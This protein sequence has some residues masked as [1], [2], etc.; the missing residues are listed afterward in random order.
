M[1]FSDI[2]SIDPDTLEEYGALDV[3]L[4]N[5][6]P[7]FVDPFLL[8]NSEKSKY[9]ILHKEIIDYLLFLRDMSQKGSISEGLIKHWFHFNEVKQNWLGFSLVGNGGRGLGDDFAHSLYGNLNRVLSNFGDEEITESSH[10]EKLCLIK[11]GVGKDSI[12]DFT[13]NL[14]KRY[15]LEYSQ[16]FGQQYLKSRQVKRVTVPRAYFNYGTRTWVSD[17][18]ALPFFQGDYVL[19]TP[20]DILARE[21]PWINNADLINKFGSIVQTVSNQELRGQLNQYFGSQLPRERKK[22]GG[23]KKPSKSAVTQAVRATINQYPQILDYYIAYKEARG[24]EA[25]S[26]S[27]AEVQIT[28]QFFIHSARQLVK[29]LY[30]NTA[31][32]KT[33]IN[34]R[35]AARQRILYLKDQIENKGAHRIFYH[36][37]IPTQRESDL[38]ILFRLTW[39]ATPHN[40]SREVNDGRG[41]VDYMISQGA[42]DKTLVEFKLAKNTQ[43]KRNLQNQ[44]TVYETASD[45]THKSLKVIMYFDDAQLEKVNSVLKELNLE[46]D[47]YIYLI[48]AGSDNKPSGSNA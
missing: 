48:N 1:Y 36:G 18:Y 12:S 40:V 29:N 9:Q 19:L 7:L 22:R 44:T 42:F 34:T 38:Q 25:V 39:F 10:L 15:L 2:F 26:L 13:T 24:D 3:S 46:K 8:F 37:D 45:A 21:E 28:E 33:P 4:I 14:I 47:E 43:L 16:T 41:P 17:T 20:K 11:D 6:L 23:Y 31:F 30:E 27:E 5:D 35:E 32:Y